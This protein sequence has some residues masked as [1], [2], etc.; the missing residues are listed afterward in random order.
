[1]S[2]VIAFVPARGGSER[3]RDKNCREVGGVPLARLTKICAARAWVDVTI[4][5]TDS[6]DVW[7][8]AVGDGPVSPVLERHHRPADLAGPHSQI[9]EAIAHWMHR[10]DPVLADEDIIILA[11][12]TTPFRK[13]ETIREC[14]RLVRAG[15]DSVTTVTLDG[16]NMGRLRSHEDGT[17]LVRWNRPI[18]ARPRSQDA[19]QLGVESGCVWAFSAAHF[20]RTKLRQG[21]R[22]AAVVTSWL[23]AFEVDTIS[24]LEVA[25]A[26][27]GVVGG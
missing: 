11:Q 24:D 13:P 23:E 14:V 4:I 3:L 2:R 1:M 20:R 25:R 5:S 12:P 18:D 17:P 26:L 6:D 15:F 21:G 16:R 8:S 22:E 7:Y 10:C 27:A 19:R 9:E